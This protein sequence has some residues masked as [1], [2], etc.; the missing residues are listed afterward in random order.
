MN[1]QEILNKM[2]FWEDK[3]NHAIDRNLVGG[4]ARISRH[5]ERLDAQLETCEN[6]TKSGMQA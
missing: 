4:M 1:E 3:L 2:R 5:L 6:L